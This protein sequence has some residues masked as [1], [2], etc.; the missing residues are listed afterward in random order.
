MSTGRTN[1]RK[2]P[3]TQTPIVAALYPGAVVRVQKTDTDWW[4]ARPNKGSAFDGFIRQD[5]L[6]FK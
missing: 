4:R 2:G 5:R 3:S 6:V 1:V